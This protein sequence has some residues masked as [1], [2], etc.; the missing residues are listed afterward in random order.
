MSLAARWAAWDRWSPSNPAGPF[1]GDQAPTAAVFPYAP[2]PVIVELNVA[3]NSWIDITNRVRRE[4][5]ISIKRGQANEASS[6][7]PGSM[8]LTLDNRDGMFCPRNPVSPLYGFI[9]R[10]TP[11]RVR[12]EMPQL[13]E[14]DRVRFVG[15]VSEWPPRWDVS[16]RDS[17]V[18]VTAQGV[19]RRLGQGA[20]PL[21]SP[22]RSF[23][24]NL[25]NAGIPP[26]FVPIPI[27]AYWPCE[28][29]GLATSIAPGFIGDSAMAYS[30]TRPDF[31]GIA[32]FL[33]SDNVLVLGA[34]TA[35]SGI[36][37]RSAAT[38]DPFEVWDVTMI[39]DVPTSPSWADGTSLLRV[40]QQ[41]IG[42]SVAAWEV[43][44]KTT[45]GGDI[46]LASLDSSGA[47]LATSATLDANINGGQFILY[48]RT[49]PSGSDVSLTVSLSS[50]DV[51]GNIVNASVSSTFAGTA[52]TRVTRI[53][54]A[55][56]GG[57]TDL[58][59][60]H[61]WLN[62]GGALDLSV[63]MV[64]Y[65]SEEADQRA[66]RLCTEN[67]VSF[68]LV[69]TRFQSQAMGPQAVLSTFLDNLNETYKADVGLLYETRD[70]LGLTLRTRRTLYNQD[71]FLDLDYEGGGEV[72]PDLQPVDDDQQTRNRVTVTRKSG[73]VS[74]SSATYED[75]TSRMGTQA[76]PAGVG[77][78]EDNVDV[79]V[80][81]DD[82]LPSH[83]RWRVHVGTWDEARFPAVPIDLAAL[84]KAGKTDLMAAATAL[85]VGDRLH[86]ANL[87]A[88]AGAGDGSVDL[89][90]WGFTETIGHPIDWDIVVNTAPSGP[91]AVG[92][93]QAD[94]V[95]P[96]G[97]PT[98]YGAAD[99]STVGSFN[100]GTDTSLSV[101]AGNGS[102]WT[103]DAAHFPLLIRASGVVLEVTAIA[104]SS[105]PQTFTV[106]ATP[107]NGITKTIPP[108]S[109]V[110]VVDQG[111][112][113]L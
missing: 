105:S 91:Y 9:G 26:F 62:Y 4:A 73:D 52:A 79:N 43:R 83:A 112:Y 41:P 100:A 3:P 113:A 74:G 22:L 87:P 93:W 17:T 104:G 66:L 109:T 49:F 84:A 55:P 13:A 48:L 35:L 99:S 11:V 24:G 63:P 34:T 65:S 54:V 59:V 32:G 30:G 78:Y 46:Q 29:G 77:P 7:E 50:L 25:P 70:E 76:P 23:I 102:L 12:L 95:D 90:A 57:M 21:Q 20:K 36:V 40:S 71:V 86:I 47:V 5:G 94:G 58:G 68:Q 14:A 16:G 92:T 18:S 8:T 107:V 53:Q 45:T 111:Y 80:E 110:D 10:N 64:S 33:G 60:G 1:G 89:L 101:D 85:D 67:D 82:D 31:A 51:N 61:V 28:D 69:G 56:N 37:T 96:A 103:T 19:L 6:P 15:E 81:S 44:Y 42:T 88:F 72:A 39:I 108:G 106:T 75:S 98:R 2:L 38:L 27:Y 97:R